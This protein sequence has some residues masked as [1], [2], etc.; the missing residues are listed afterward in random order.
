MMERQQE[1]RE[2]TLR[3][4]E[5]SMAYDRQIHA[6]RQDFLRSEGSMDGCG[7]LRRMETTQ[8]WLDQVEQFRHPETVPEGF[9]EATQYL[10]VRE[11]DQKVVGMLQIRHWLNENLRR[12]G[13][14]IGYSV[15]PSERRKGYATRMLRD[16]LPI[17]KSLGMDRVMISCIRENEAS[18]RVILNNGGVY[19]KTVLEPEKNRYLEHYW[20][21]L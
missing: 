7:S 8:E 6:Y 2:E 17:C 15:C 19:A 16:A 5:P 14:H 10:Y 3:L 1:N 9:V 18:R 21:T 4:V 12:Y 13:G 11:L 20:I